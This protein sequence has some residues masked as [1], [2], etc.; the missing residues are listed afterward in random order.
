VTARCEKTAYQIIYLSLEIKIM[1]LQD[2][3]NNKGS[4][5]HTIE[6]GCMLDEVAHLLVEHRIGALLV[7]KGGQSGEQ[8]LLGIVTER[9]ILY[10]C[11]KS[12][13]PLAAV[14]VTT[15]MSSPLIT[16]APTDS[17]DQCMG[18]MTAKRIRHLPVLEK[19]RLV[20][21]ISIGDL[22]KA[23]HD[24][25]AMENRFMKDYIRG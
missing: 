13:L 15:V 4:V 19:G 6:P 10:H 1:S 22:V 25:L 5:V 23:Q 20:G 2:I 7:S 12:N 9:D 16:A 11:A 18:V 3:L 14:E 24:H 8:E 17:V 21:L